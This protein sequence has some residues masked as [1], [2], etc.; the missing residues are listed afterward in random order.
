MTNNLCYLYHLDKTSL[1]IHCNSNQ[2]NRYRN[3]IIKSICDNEHYKTF[4]T[5]VLYRK[6]CCCQAILP[7][8][9]S[10]EKVLIFLFFTTSNYQTS[11]LVQIIPFFYLE[12]FYYYP[13]SSIFRCIYSSDIQT[14]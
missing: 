10:F 9:F 11:K 1:C 3:S 6:S 12:N 14:G 13:Y 4:S 5:I 8:G 2:N 7:I